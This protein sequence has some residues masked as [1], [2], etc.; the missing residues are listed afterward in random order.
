MYSI[1]FIPLS[2]EYAFP[3]CQLYV[4]C[5]RLV[6]FIRFMWQED[7]NS[8]GFCFRYSYYIHVT[9]AG[10]LEELHL[11]SFTYAVSQHADIW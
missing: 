10:H 11:Q 7:L 4:R 8:T 2:L 6:T 3:V 1:L 5:R 9:N